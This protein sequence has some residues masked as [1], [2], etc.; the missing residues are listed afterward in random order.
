MTKNGST[1]GGVRVRLGV[2]RG[3]AMLGAVLT[4]SACERGATEAEARGD[5]ASQ[6]SQAAQRG[7]G[8]ASSGLPP[9]AMRVWTAA[10]RETCA[11]M[12]GRYS[13]RDV[14]FAR[15]VASDDDPA[16][17]IMGQLENG[18]N[19]YIVAELNGD[20]RDDYIVTL[21]NSGCEFDD[22]DT[23]GGGDPYGRAGPSQDFLISTPTGYRMGIDIRSPL[24]A[25][26]SPDSIKRRGDR[27]VVELT[28]LPL[29]FRRCGAVASAIWGWNG[30]QITLLE[31]RDDGGR[32]VDEEGCLIE[33]ATRDTRAGGIG[34]SPVGPLNIVPGYYVH[35]GERCETAS[36]AF[37]YDGR[38]VG[39]RR[40]DPESDAVG[41]I[42]PVDELPDSMFV[43]YLGEWEWA[44]LR[45]GPA[46]I[47][48][49]MGMPMVPCDPDE[50]PAGLRV[51]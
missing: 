14:R 35:E 27:D 12:E 26:I 3:L 46:R 25:W 22:A 24:Q 6:P 15:N 34:A 37:F 41:P 20:G 4:I 32:I 18:T 19:I 45:L 44:V 5:S 47:Q 21:G 36:T 51:E 33:A 8:P 49:N 39:P 31:R 50:L 42:G 13:G 16:G 23:D 9:E 29:P 1:G 28:G 2:R 10:Q 48:L 11:L 40:G 30:N 38:R 7:A 17:D 43:F